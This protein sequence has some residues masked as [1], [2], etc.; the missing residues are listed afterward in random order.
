MRCLKREKIQTFIDNE[1]SP[2]ERK[3]VEEHLSQCSTCRDILKAAKEE[4]KFIDTKLESL[5]PTAIPQLRRD[6]FIIPKS[7][8]R[9]RPFLIRL[10]FAKVKVP[11]PALVFLCAVILA[12][13]AMLYSEY[14]RSVDLVTT[15]KKTPESNSLYLNYKDNMHS[16]SVNFDLSKFRPIE[17]PEIFVISQ[18]E[19]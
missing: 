18:E 6:E 4:I 11:I 3:K 9:R 10:I 5:N 17:K 2:K 19:K 14:N 12:L 1:L 15:R 16:I 13:S 8:K 7:S